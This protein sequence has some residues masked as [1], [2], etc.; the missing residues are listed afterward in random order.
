MDQETSDLITQIS[1]RIGMIMEDASV[2]A[3]TL[4]RVGSAL[5][6]RLHISRNCFGRFSSMLTV[7]NSRRAIRWRICQIERQASN[8]ADG[9]RELT[10]YCGQCGAAV[11]ATNRFC[12]NCGVPLPSVEES[13]TSASVDPPAIAPA[14]IS[15][16][17]TASAPLALPAAMLVN[18][19][20]FFFAYALLMVPTYVLPYFGSNS[21]LLN[22]VGVAAGAGALPQFWLHLICLYLLAAISWIRGGAIGKNWLPVLP[23]IAALFDLMPGLNWV[24]LVPTV[25]HVATLILGVKGQAQNLGGAILARRVLF[26]LIGL[27]VLV[28]LMIYQAT[29]FASGG[30]SSEEID[31]SSD[32]SSVNS[33]PNAQQAPALP[34]QPP[35]N[36]Q[37]QGKLPDYLTGR[38]STKES[39]NGVGSDLEILVT[40]DK[41]QF[42]EA[43]GR[44]RSVT[45][46]GSD[47]LVTLDMEGE[48]QRYVSRLRVMPSADGRS[49]ETSDP[50]HLD[51]PP[52]IYFESALNCDQLIAN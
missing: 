3:L 45:Q 50:D 46:E 29:N 52:T 14:D 15:Q 42:Y 51:V 48:G 17:S 38:W 23:G 33:G 8:F 6:T 9:G 18:P 35:P 7:T 26:T 22:S 21:A 43:I 31:Q 25:L 24:P 44:V 19:V 39:C 32:L 37:S 40:P 2:I 20:I 16:A 34:T 12:Q 30:G 28:V 1:T 13:P 49:F 41:I 4:G 27:G 36:V 5:G 11:P 47:Y 10:K